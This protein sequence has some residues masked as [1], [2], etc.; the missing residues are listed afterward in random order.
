MSEMGSAAV[1]IASNRGP[2]SFSRDDTGRLVSSRGGGGL[3]SAM[4]A[5]AAAPDTL[6]LCAALSDADREAAASSRG[7]RIDE[8]GHD[9]AGAAVAMLP[10]DAGVLAGAYTGI[11]NSTL[12]SVNHGLL[13]PV[14]S[15]DDAWRRDWSSYVD[16][17]QTFAAAIADLAA[18]GAR[19]LVQDYHLDLVP[20]A[21]HA[22]RPDLRIGHFTHTPWATATDFAQLPADV[23]EAL[24]LGVLGADSIGFHSP[25]WAADFAA[26]AGAV[27]GTTYDGEAVVHGDRRVPLR[28]HPLGVDAEPLRAR[29][30]EPD[31]SHRLGGLRGLIGAQQ[32]I[33]R[34]D[35][36]EPAKNIHRG[37][38]A[39]A[40]L[41]RDHPEHL[42]HAVHVA[43]AY[44]SRQDVAEY[45]DYTADCIAL[46]A[47]I[48]AELSTPEWTPVLF[49]VRDDYARSLATLRCTDVL[50]VNSL[51]DGMNLVAKEGVLLGDHT[52]LVLSSETGAADEMGAAALLVDPLD[53]EA[54]AAALH[55]ALTMP[56]AERAH[57]HS[58]LVR[59]ATAFPPREW[60]QAQLDALD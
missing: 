6:W 51:R 41:F 44:P 47:E 1:V 31:V 40:L 2:L 11:S 32:V 54:T 39:I 10:I 49:N 20:A 55:A 4:I 35:R 58:D 52:V 27:L 30:A 12:W 8:A 56:A 17:N 15:F 25:R 36:T 9:T 24:L 19:V 33:G 37:L 38:L 23:A 53:V 46:A 29:A 16:Y 34:V 7:G 14:I 42:G 22:L 5:A 60:L 50:L 43:L 18:V 3:V 21:L 45:R 59:S 48:N 28:V 57:R 13:D 26:C